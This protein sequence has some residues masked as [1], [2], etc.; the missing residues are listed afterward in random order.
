MGSPIRSGHPNKDRKAQRDSL[1][2]RG[3]IYNCVHR[4]SDCLHRCLRCEFRSSSI[5]IFNTVNRGPNRRAEK[6]LRDIE[7]DQI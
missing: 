1:Y 6:A 4:I 5:V 7:R 3:G 2:E